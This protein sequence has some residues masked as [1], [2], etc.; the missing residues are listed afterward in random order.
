MAMEQAK[1]LMSAE[2]CSV[3]LIDL[4]Q[5]DLVE[6]YDPMQLQMVSLILKDSKLGVD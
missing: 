6:I 4:D 3:M 1:M 5:M 2:Y